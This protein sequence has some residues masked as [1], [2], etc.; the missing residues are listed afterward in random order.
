[1]TFDKFDS[2]KKSNFVLDQILQEIHSQ[3][4]EV[5][6]CIPTEGKLAEEM[7]VSRTSVREALAA[8]RLVGVV[9]S[10]PGQGTFISKKLS[11][12]NGNLKEEALSVLNENTSP[13][14][15]FELR[16]TIEGPIAVLAMEKMT[17]SDLRQLKDV[18]DRM[19]EATKSGNKEK[20]FNMNTKFHLLVAKG[21]HNKALKNIMESTLSYMNEDLWKEEREYYF[22]ENDAKLSRCL[23][24]HKNIFNALKN[25]DKPTLLEEIDNHFEYVEN[26]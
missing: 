14:E 3:R 1:M 8:L 9:T 5:G 25:E 24:I 22:Q 23:Q 4:Y 7:G 17:D 11:K 26:G 12:E 6:D 10:K 18:L 21:T 16:E 19:T 13:D 15:M 2:T 20:Y